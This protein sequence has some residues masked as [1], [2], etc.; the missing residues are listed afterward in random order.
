MSVNLFWCF[1]DDIADD[2][3]A[4]FGLEEIRDHNSEQRIKEL[5]VTSNLV[6]DMAR[7]VASHEIVTIS[8]LEEILDDLDDGGFSFCIRI[9]MVVSGIGHG[10]NRVGI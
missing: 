4:R 5:S 2:C 1:L 6:S 10:R 3:L 9:V 8:A 7:D